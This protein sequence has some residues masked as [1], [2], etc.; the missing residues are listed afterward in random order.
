MNTGELNSIY[1]IC[2][3]SEGISAVLVTSGLNRKDRYSSILFTLHP[4]TVVHTSGYRYQ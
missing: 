3:M 1:T 2:F 4:P